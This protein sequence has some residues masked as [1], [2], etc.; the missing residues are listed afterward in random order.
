M[1][2]ITILL[3]A[4]VVLMPSVKGQTD[5]TSNAFRS[6][7]VTLSN[8]YVKH[9]D[10][11]ANLLDMA[12]FYAHKDNPQHNYVHAAQYL[13]RAEELYT[14]WL[15]DRGRYRDMQKLIKNALFL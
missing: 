11:V 15:Q 3:V 9:P 14:A 12:S 7:Y 8:Q 5:S 1:K 4:C 10:D 13:Q 2:R 6:L